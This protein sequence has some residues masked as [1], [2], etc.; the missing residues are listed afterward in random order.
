M[1]WW[2]KTKRH[3]IATSSTERNLVG[4]GSLR[5]SIGGLDNKCHTPLYILI[6]IT[7]FTILSIIILSIRFVLTGAV[8]NEGMVT[9]ND[10]GA[11][12]L[13]SVNIDKLG[14]TNSDGSPITVTYSDG[15]TLAPNRNATNSD[16]TNKNEVLNNDEVVYDVNLNITTPGQI[17]LSLTMPANNVINEASVSEANGCLSGSKVESADITNSDGAITKSYTNNKATCI[18]N[19]TTTGSLTWSVSTNPWGGNNEQITPT[20]AISNQTQSTTTSNTPIPTVTTIGKGDYGMTVYTE[21]TNSAANGLDRTVYPTFGIYGKNADKT[22]ALGLSPLS[23]DGDWIV[24][25]DT[26]G[27]PKG[28]TIASTNNNFREVAGS[29]GGNSGMVNSGQVEATK[30]SDDVLEIRWR[31]S[32]TA[33]GHCPSQTESGDEIDDDICYYMGAGVNIGSPV[34]SLTQEP[35]NYAIAVPNVVAKLR[36]Q[37]DTVI[38]PTPNTYS[39]TMTSKAY[40]NPT[41]WAASPLTLVGWDT[42]WDDNRPV[43]SGQQVQVGLFIQQNTVPTSNRATNLYYCATWNP[44]VLR[45]DGDFNKAPSNNSGVILSDYA[46]EY[47]VIGTNLDTTYSSAQATCG[48]YGDGKASFFASLDEADEYATSHNL[49]VNAIRLWSAETK[50]GVRVGQLGKLLFRPTSIMNDSNEARAVRMYASGVTNEWNERYVGNHATSDGPRLWEHNLAPGLLSHTITAEP[51]STAPNTEE[52]ITITPTTYN[53]DT[54]VKITTTLPKGLTPKD[55]SFKIT[56]GYESDG[57][58]I[59]RQLTRGDDVESNDYAIDKSNN[60]DTTIIFNLDH[61]SETYGIAITGYNSIEPGQAGVVNIVNDDGWHEQTRYNDTDLPIAAD[62]DGKG[63]VH[64]NTPISFDAVVDSDVSTPNSLAIKSVVSGTGTDFASAK[65][66]SAE[67]SVSVATERRFDYSLSAS[68]DEIYA[69]DDLAYVIGNY[70]TLDNLVGNLTT[71]NVLPYN[72]DSRGTRGLRSDHSYSLTEITLRSND[73]SNQTNFWSDVELYYTTD[74]VVRSLERGDPTGLVNNDLVAWQKVN[75]SDAT[76][77]DGRLNV[78]IPDDIC[79]SGQ[80]DCITGFMIKKGSLDSGDSLS[81]AYKLTNISADNGGVGIIGNSINYTYA[82]AIAAPAINVSTIA[83]NYLGATLALTLDKDA[84]YVQL[85][86]NSVILGGR[87]ADDSLTNIATINART[88]RGYNLTMQAKTVNGELVGI[89]DNTRSIPTITKQ[90]IA[91]TKG[92]ANWAMTITGSN[93]PDLLAG[94]SSNTTTW[95][96]IPGQNSSALS[97]YTTTIPGQDINRQLTITY[98]VSTGQNTVADTYRAEVVYTLVAEP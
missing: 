15:S 10:S 78:A 92:T 79:P 33:V 21:A 86:P 18:I 3:S 29:G 39:W 14:S 93:N 28:W 9:L 38:E 56:V 52:H 49:K 90:G 17:T 73:S 64:A 45:L 65:F 61:I 87:Q 71:V 84:L 67:A 23:S 59:V 96:P 72:G 5:I 74:S 55:N 44:S 43:Y 31:G 82:D 36:Y 89:Q 63:I 8:G 24:Q 98:G 35:K 54:N 11:A 62:N 95:L 48:R 41:I 66:K 25:I 53:R 50:S 97:L 12:S 7:L 80:L 69:G 75:L 70:N 42:F 94:S 30:I 2:N 88:S 46:V 51:S 40:G 77:V 68:A 27:L 32:V 60:G 85:E 57:R 83:T 4:G 20:I 81:L 34:S 58:P 16:S 19:P 6:T 1:A 22:G 37:G 91:P 47:G 13:T 76:I 26:S